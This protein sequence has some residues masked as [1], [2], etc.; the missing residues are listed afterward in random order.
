[1]RKSRITLSAPK[2]SWRALIALAIAAPA[3]TVALS[4]ATA[5]AQGFFGLDIRIDDI[6]IGYAPPPL[7]IYDQPPL[8]GPDYIWV[9]GYWAWSD[10][11]DDYYWV[12][13]YW[14][15]PPESGLVW[16][17]AWWGW[18]DGAYR[19]HEGYWGREVGWY[20]GID[21]GHGYHGHGWEGGHWDHG[22]VSYNRAVVNVT[23]VNVTN[24]YYAP[25]TVNR[26]PRVSY[27][28][29]EGGVRAQPRPEELR[30]MNAPHFAPTPMQQ[31]R[32]QQAAS[33]PHA[34]A[35]QIT[36][37][38]H[39]PAVHRVGTNGVPIP[40]NEALTHGGATAGAPPAYR[41][42][43][44]Q[45]QPGQTPHP[46]QQGQATPGYGQTPRPTPQGQTTPGY[47]QTPHPTPQGQTTPGYGQTPHP[48]PQGQTTP[49]FAHPPAQ[50]PQIHATPPAASH[51]PTPKPQ[52]KP[53]AQPDRDHHDHP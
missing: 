40:R 45:G 33:N 27:A 11:I 38:W 43:G 41:H 5:H 36:P 6:R 19:F 17:P 42:P 32:V 31:Q 7:P 29:G 4:P 3:V 1:M 18:D 49:G 51:P 24:V 44:S 53:N 52:P 23:N 30:A 20:G 39:P 2:V 10:W 15:L 16:T 34:V 48:T 13:G 9:P 47:S 8:P 35:S 46:T 14:D 28:G 37:T 50:Q 26:G 12:A 25:V 21:Y 22:H